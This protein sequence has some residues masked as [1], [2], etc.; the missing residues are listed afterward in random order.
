MVTRI[1]AISSHTIS[2]NQNRLAML[3]VQILL[4]LVFFEKF[5]ILSSEK[6]YMNKVPFLRSDKILLKFVHPISPFFQD[7]I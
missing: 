5:I 4:K 3:D 6:G 1:L 2:S 7:P